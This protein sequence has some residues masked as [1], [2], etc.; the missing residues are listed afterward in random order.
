MCPIDSRDDI[1]ETI[2]SKVSSSFLVAVICMK[3][4]DELA[5]STIEYT[6]YEL[7]ATVSGSIGNAELLWNVSKIPVTSHTRQKNALMK[8][9]PK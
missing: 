6:S 8:V 1:G 3:E 5:T 4:L 2:S 7:H 9:K